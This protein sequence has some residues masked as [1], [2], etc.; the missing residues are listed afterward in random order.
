MALLKSARPELQFGIT[1]QLQPDRR[2]TTEILDQ[3]CSYKGCCSNDPIFQDNQIDQRRADLLQK[4]EKIVRDTFAIGEEMDDEDYLLCPCWV[5]GFVL[6][7]RKWGQSNFHSHASVQR[8][9]DKQPF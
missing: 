2:E 6:R 4:D 1:T 9:I 8:L 5:Y 7:S 3:M